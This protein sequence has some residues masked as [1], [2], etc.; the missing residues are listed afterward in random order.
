MSLLLI[1]TPNFFAGLVFLI[2]F[3]TPE[4]FSRC[5]VEFASGGAPTKRSIGRFNGWDVTGELKP[6]FRLRQSIPLPLSSLKIYLPFPHPG[7]L[8][9]LSTGIKMR[10][11]PI[12]F[13]DADAA[14][15]APFDPL[16]AMSF[17]S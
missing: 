15:I 6:P 13:E 16:A 1:Q 3:E 5:L 11:E 10:G 4:S 8:F 17:G 12:L 2:G 7:T 9:Q 14:G